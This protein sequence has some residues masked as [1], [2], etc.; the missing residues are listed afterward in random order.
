MKSSVEPH[1]IDTHDEPC[2]GPVDRKLLGT[3]QEKPSI[4]DYY[5]DADI[6]GTT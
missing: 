1:H 5:Q 2:E 6:K 4:A 3:S